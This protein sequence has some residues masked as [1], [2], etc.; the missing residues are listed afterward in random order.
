M[1]ALSAILVGI[2]VF[3]PALIPNSAAVVFGG[4]T[5]IDLGRTWRGK[6]ILGDGKTWRGFFGGTLSGILLGLLQISAGVL[7]GSP[8]LLGFGALPE[9]AGVVAALALG[10]L[11]G[12]MAGAFVKRRL[13]LERGAKAVGLDQYDFVAGAM[14]LTLALFPAWFM[15]R[16]VEGHGLLALA[17]LLL[18]VP[19]LHRLVNIIGYRR[20]LKKEPW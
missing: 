13:G 20:G 12:D 6:R 7:A 9:A 4:G 1:D 19:F 8:D 16:Y 5:P 17:A 18:F 14:L 15:A 2:W 11:L 3:L 10:S